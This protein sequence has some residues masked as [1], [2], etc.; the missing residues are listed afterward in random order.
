MS[1][2]ASAVVP[3]S[4]RFALTNKA[5]EP[6]TFIDGVLLSLCGEIVSNWF[7]DLAASN[8]ATQY[9]AF[10]APQTFTVAVQVPPR[11]V[12]TVGVDLETAATTASFA[13]ALQVPR[14][15]ILLK[16]FYMCAC[17]V[18]CSCLHSHASFV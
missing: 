15:N 5:V 14:T 2:S 4:K 1:C 8:L 16:V 7:T 17:P 10:V 9:D 13:A 12:D 3:A 18:L 6:F 11:F